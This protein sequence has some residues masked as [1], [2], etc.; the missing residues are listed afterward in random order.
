MS[1]LQSLPLATYSQV[2]NQLRPPSLLNRGKLM[3]VE[4]VNSG[5]IPP[6]HTSPRT[7]CLTPVPQVSIQS[8]HLSR[9]VVDG[10]ERRRR[11]HPNGMVAI[12][13]F[14]LSVL[15]LSTSKAPSRPENMVSQAAGSKKSLLNSWKGRSDGSEDTEEELSQCNVALPRSQVDIRS[16]RHKAAW[17]NLPQC[18]A[19]EQVQ[20]LDLCTP[21][22]VCESNKAHFT[23][24]HRPFPLGCLPTPSDNS[25]T[26]TLLLG[27]SVATAGSS[28]TCSEEMDIHL[29]LSSPEQ[30]VMLPESLS[31]AAIITG[32]KIPAPSPFPVN[33]G[34][35]HRPLKP[36]TPTEKGTI[37]ASRKILPLNSFSPETLM[38]PADVEKENAHFCV[39]DIIISAMETMKYNLLNQQQGES[40]KELETS[41]SFG[42]DQVDFERGFY[43]PEK[44]NSSSATSSDS[45]YE[46]CSALQINPVVE[47]SICQNTLKEICECDSDD[48]VLVEL[49]DFG[50]ITETCRCFLD[51]NKRCIEEPGYNSAE[52]IAKDLYQ[53]FCRRCRLAESDF[54]LAGSPQ[55]D[56]SI[57]VNEDSFQKHFESSLDVV[58]EIK[59]KS[60]IKGTKDWTPPRFEIILTVHPPQKRDFVV[61]A[62]N[63][64]CAGCGTP[65]EQKYI[66]RLR[67]C[68]Y[69][70]KYF[71]D[72]CHN[73][74]E[75]YIPARILMKWDF[76]K[77]HVSK[78]S[79]H[80]LDSIWHQPLF[81]LLYISQNL[82]SKAKELDQVREIQEKLVQIK[83]LLKTC[84]FAE[85][86]L[87]DFEQVPGHL[88]N[89]LHLFSLN[90]LVKIKKGQLAAV[91]R[92][93]LK[94]SL[95]HVDS[96]ELCQG[97]GYIC[98]FCQSPAVIFPFQMTTCKRCT[99]C[100]A[101]FHKQCFRSADCP[102]CLRIRARRKLLQ[103][104][105]SVTT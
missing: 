84:R 31:P 15:N 1:S 75:S 46:G 50:K 26:E 70:G 19:E 58:E 41:C 86:V 73:Y 32:S 17:I 13:E 51:Q 72:C 56:G 4:S 33:T 90:D 68:D 55:A 21:V 98:E 39:A 16:M 92:V 48:F 9:S 79:K 43:L 65:I 66:K 49:E 89:E 22:P 34:A 105:P 40:R 14:L 87:K 78:F 8:D 77:Y 7:S 27:D 100:K 29:S 93:L 53:A 81:N 102:K 80:L 38:L 57:I 18:A 28:L 2:T 67:Y 54:H 25:L 35:S 104:L 59:F 30:H 37:S 101:C 24:N 83:K 64:S 11:P 62:Q 74:A 3:C 36:M 5:H 52:L 20:L 91:L 42:S 97:K 44:Q 71:C 76:R 99:A 45:G 95:V 88:T 69:L 103:S 12:R 82:Y 61:S 63:F 96:C 60:R 85:R 23:T 10:H 47:T 6:S 94:A